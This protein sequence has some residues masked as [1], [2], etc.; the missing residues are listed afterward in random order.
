MTITA[1]ILCYELKNH[2]S[3]EINLSMEEDFSIMGFRIWEGEKPEKG[4]LYLS[5]QNVPD[6]KAWRESLVLGIQGSFKADRKSPYILISDSIRFFQLINYVQKVFQNHYHTCLHMEKI[7]SQNKN[8]NDIL[9]ILEETYDIIAILE[10]NNMKFIAMSDGYRSCNQWMSNEESVPLEVAGNLMDDE[11]FCIA[12]NHD[13]SFPYFYSDG[14]LS[15]FSY[16]YNIKIEG[17]YKARFM[18]QKRDG[19]P[20]YGGLALAQLLGEKL[21]TVFTLYHMEQKQEMVAAEFY[22]MIRDLLQ[23]VSKDSVQL[24]R[25]LSIRSWKKDHTYQVYLFE[26]IKEDDAAVIWR[27]YQNK[28][29]DLL[30]DCCVLIFGERLC[31]VRN[32][33]NLSQDEWDIRQNLVIFLRE[34]LYKAGISQTVQDIEKLHTCYVQAVNSLEIGMQSNST[35]WYYNFEDMTLPYIWKQATLEMDPASLYHPAIRI[36]MEY[37]RK[38]GTNL[39]RTVFAFIRNRYNVTH[40]AKELYIHRTTLLFRLDRIEILTGLKWDN[41]KDRIHLAVTFELLKQGLKDI[42]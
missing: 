4:I 27:Y 29:E 3:C 40:T 7:F 21:K 10:D 6:G 32:L 31:C 28:L 42:M 39:T 19:K 23:G 1:G 24:D 34:N 14:N 33:S 18:I 13:R 26:L 17:E 36:L 5:D 11:K 35:N 22:S 41:W 8:F 20:F 25:V 37:D 30:G 15:R 2:F 38:E 16:C 9:N 12:V